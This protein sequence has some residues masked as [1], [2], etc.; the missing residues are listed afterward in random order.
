[1][2]NNEIHCPKC[3]ARFFHGKDLSMG[4]MAAQIL[5][6]IGYRER[7]ST[8]ASYINKSEMTAIYNWL[9][10]KTDGEA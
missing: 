9:L 4:Q 5:E 8:V 2:S 7:S 10:E 3:E 6:H 1:V